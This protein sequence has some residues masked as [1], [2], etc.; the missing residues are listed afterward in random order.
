[1]YSTKEEAQQ[2]A[3]D[4]Y[5][6]DTDNYGHHISN[7]YRIKETTINTEIHEIK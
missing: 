4:L 1:M 5:D 6:G 2:R 3:K 7:L